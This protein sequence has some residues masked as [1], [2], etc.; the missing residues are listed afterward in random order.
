MIYHGE[1]G[2][3]ACPR[4]LVLAVIAVA[5][6][7]VGCGDTHMSLERERI[8]VSRELANV[9]SSA[10]N[11]NEMFD[12]AP[13]VESAAARIEKLAE[14]RGKLKPASDAEKTQIAKL[15]E[16]GNAEMKAKMEG[17]MKDKLN[18]KN[19]LSGGLPDAAKMQKFLTA[20]ARLAKA[21]MTFDPQIARA[22]APTFGQMD[23]AASPLPDGGGGGLLSLPNSSQKAGKP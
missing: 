13:Q 2:M 23:G 6:A 19:M 9:L 8:A 5:L 14:R 3:S 10:N 7:S 20:M 18:P 17:A 22:G 16:E 11:P 12:K 15:R 1:P 21:N 4:P